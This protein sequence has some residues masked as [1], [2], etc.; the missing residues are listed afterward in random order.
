MNKRVLLDLDGVI[1]DFYRGFA[2]FLNKNYGCFLPLDKDPSGYYFG[3][4]GF[5]INDIDIPEAINAWISN[6]GFLNLLAYPGAS[7]FTKKL[8][9]IADVYIITARVGDWERN[10]PED[11]VDK[12]KE[13]TKKWLV[14]EDISF[15]KLFFIHDKVDFCI[16][17]GISVIIE[18]KAETVNKA[19]LANIPSILVNKKYNQD[20]E[21]PKSNIYRVDNFDD[22]LRYL[23]R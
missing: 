20:V 23:G 21:M 9:E 12:I 22:I 2:R 8:N 1:A 6:D 17:N 15:N 5:G 3:D 13:D 4:W 14:R 18:D 11:I 7:E 16:N 10:I 19:S